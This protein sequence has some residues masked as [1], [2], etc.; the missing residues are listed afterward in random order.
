MNLN[1][2][3]GVQMSYQSQYYV[4]PCANV[5]ASNT[6]GCSAQ[7]CQGGTP[8]SEYDPAVAVWT[9]TDTGV[10]QQIQNGQGCGGNGP[11]QST[12]RFI[13]NATATTPFIL[14]EYE[15]PTCHY[16]LDIATSAA[17]GVTVPRSVGTTWASD[18]CGGGAYNLN[19][20]S[21]GNDIT[22]FDSQGPGYVFINPCGIVYNASC[23]GANA[24]VCY[25]YTPLNF[26]NPNNDYNLATWFDPAHRPDTPH[27]HPTQ[28]P[29]SPL[30]VSRGLCYFS[31]GTPPPRPCVTRCW[32]TA[33]RRRT[34]TAGTAAPSPARPASR[35]SATRRPPRLW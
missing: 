2:I 5:L 22:Y 14:T 35:T 15:G 21:P 25:A 26:T 3:A 18:L 10:M 30:M 28:S 1:S 33:S 20:V 13:C 9:L 16:T 29:C 23:A 12:L 4:S 19:L 31:A 11:R 27:C 17:C 8:L 7:A 32:P 6:G 24:A 34:W